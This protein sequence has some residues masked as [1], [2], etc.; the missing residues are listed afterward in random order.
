MSDSPLYGKPT[1]CGLTFK[2]DYKFFVGPTYTKY[3]H[4]GTS[5]LLLFLPAIKIL[6]APDITASV[7]IYRGLRRNYRVQALRISSS[8]QPSR[9]WSF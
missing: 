5:H 6:K 2:W 7:G 4:S 8:S 3:E 1:N 9:S